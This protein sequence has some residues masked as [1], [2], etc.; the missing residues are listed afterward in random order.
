M[1]GILV[2]CLRFKVAALLGLGLC[3]VLCVCGLLVLCWFDCWFCVVF[4]RV[5]VWWVDVPVYFVC[6]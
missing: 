4:C 2:C 3:V 6:C 1:F 5:A